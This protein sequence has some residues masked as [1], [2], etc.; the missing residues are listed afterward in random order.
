VEAL[1]EV[2]AGAAPINP[3][4]AGRV[5]QMFSSLAAPSSD[6]GLSP[7]EREILEL[8]T[9]GLALKQI[10][11]RLEVSYHTIDTHTRNIYSK[12][13]VHSRGG[14]VAKALRERLV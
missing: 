1:Q 7:R 8:M 4:I 2:H 5:L 13:H 6:Y 14:A 12:L 11:A 10:A 3:H 9:Q